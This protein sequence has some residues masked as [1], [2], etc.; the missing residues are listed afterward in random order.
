[1]KRVLLVEDI[2]NTRVLVGRHLSR[3]GWTIE[4][5]SS[6][7]E[8]FATLRRDSRFGVIL[9]DVGLPG[10]DGLEATRTLRQ[11]V[12]W[13][14]IPIIILTAHAS[15]NDEKK[16]MD[17]GAFSYECKPIDFDKLLRKMDAAITSPT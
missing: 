2:E 4:G 3:K 12:E 14:A 13:N 17:A 11:S 7:E 5:C 15:A 8:C 9:M 10:M 6:A 1:M 16:A